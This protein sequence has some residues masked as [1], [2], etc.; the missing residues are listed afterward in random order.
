M[1]LIKDI[2][3]EDFG[4]LVGPVLKCSACWLD[5]QV[6]DYLLKISNIHT[7]LRQAS[8]WDM[9]GLQGTFS[10]KQGLPRDSEKHRLVLENITLIHNFCTEIVRF[11]LIKTV[12]DPEYECIQTLSGSGFI[13]Q[14]YC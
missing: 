5:R 14:Y 4:I 7:S 2:L 13:W 3:G 10:C 12:I 6:Q 9:H 11:S 8:E 1:L